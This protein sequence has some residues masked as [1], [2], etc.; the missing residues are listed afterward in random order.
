MSQEKVSK[1]LGSPYSVSTIWEQQP[2][3]YEKLI[4]VMNDEP[5]HEPAPY[6]GIPWDV[7]W[8]YDSRRTKGWAKR[9]LTQE[10]LEGT[11]FFYEKKLVRFNLYYE[12]SFGKRWVF[13][14]Y[15]FP[16]A[17]LKIRKREVREAREAGISGTILTGLPAI[18]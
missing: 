6:Y 1:L 10:K 13:G 12:M 18:K 3:Y 17:L 15:P 16:P 11:V 9:L 7:S 5:I 4:A 2:G 14:Q 8:C